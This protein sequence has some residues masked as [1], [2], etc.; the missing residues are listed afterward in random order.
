MRHLTQRID[1]HSTVRRKNFLPPP[2][3]Y[4]LHVGES[5][6][7]QFFSKFVVHTVSSVFF[8]STLATLPCSK[9][10]HCP[11]SLSKLIFV[12]HRHRT[13]VGLYPR[14]GLTVSSF[15]VQERTN[16]FQN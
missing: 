14:I 1:G 11:T 4:V 5:R 8:M 15:S 13:V 10:S 7:P 16:Y 12:R 2:M 3:L 6:V 9:H